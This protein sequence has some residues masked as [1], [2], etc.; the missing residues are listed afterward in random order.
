[1]L[2]RTQEP[3]LRPLTFNN[4]LLPKRNELNNKIP[5]Y[6]LISGAQDVLRLE[7]IF[8]AGS[9][10]EPKES[11][12]HFTAKML[13]E[14]TKDFSAKEIQEKI[15]FYGAFM[16][17]NSGFDRAAFTV[18]CLA[19]HLDKLLPIISQIITEPTFP[20]QELETLKLISLQSLRVNQEKTAFLA[21]AKFRKLLFG[22]HPYGSCMTEE[23]ISSI[24]RE[25]LIQF[26]E[27]YYSLSNATILITGGG[28]TN[29]YNLIN[30]HFGIHQLINTNQISDY[31]ASL[32]TPTNEIIVKENSIQSSIR[33]GCPLFTIKHDDYFKTSILVEILGGY[34][35][36]RLMKN[37]RE[38]KGYTYGIHANF[39]VM[40]NNGYLVIGTDVNKENTKA[41]LEEIYKEI[42][43][44]KSEKVNIEELTLVKNY[45]KGSF[46]N[47]I[48]TSYSQVDKFKTLLFNNLP[49]NFYETYFNTLTHITTEEIQSIALKYFRLE[50]FYEVVVGNI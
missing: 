28:N 14:G 34:F 48:N 36:S 33:L 5:F 40:K 42:N 1:M 15:A 23:G 30:N 47:S 35:G 9:L 3:E 16:E 6:Q 12:A 11:V 39:A 32:G 17:L 20:E 49:E 44:L 18:Y 27:K 10:Y 24:S 13:S 37:I 38:D 43:L 7:I 26:H 4:I 50:N 31:A 29:Y 22:Q 8:K 46:I 21:S 45:L 25:D 41:T 19:R 2:I